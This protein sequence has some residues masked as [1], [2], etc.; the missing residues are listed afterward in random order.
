LDLTI[1]FESILRKFAVKNKVI[2]IR[3]E[4]PIINLANLLFESRKISSHNLMSIKR[5]MECRNRIVHGLYKP[6]KQELREYVNFVSHFIKRVSPE[7]RKKIRKESE[8]SILR[9]LT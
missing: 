9:Y 1:L 3:E 2:D 4:V 6:E 8:T 7:I 5:F